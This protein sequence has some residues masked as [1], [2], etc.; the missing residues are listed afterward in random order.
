MNDPGDRFL[1][2]VLEDVEQ[3]F[4][5]ALDSARAQVAPEE[6]GR[7][8]QVLDSVVFVRG[9]PKTQA[10]EMIRFPG[11]TMGLAF[12]LDPGQ[13]GV[14]MLD[15]SEGIEAG[16]RARRTGRVMDVPVGEAVVGRVLDPVGRPLDGKGPIQTQDRLELER[17]AADILDRDPV[18]EPLQTG[19]KVID[20]LIPIGRGQRELIVGDRQTGKTAIAT[21]A[22][23]NQAR[24]NVTCIY[25]AIGRRKS[26]V[27]KVIADLE[28]RGAM[29]YSAVVVAGGEDAPG[30]RFAAPYSAMSMAE[31]LMYKGRDV[32]VVFDDLTR[33]ARAYRELSL[34]LRRPPGREAYPGDIFYIHSRLLER[35]THLSDQ[36]G[37][38][39]VTA[40]PI[41]ETQAQNISAYIPT[42]LISITD[43]QIYLSPTLFQQGQLPAVDVG[44]SVSRVGGKA[45][46]DP[47]RETAGDL[48][49]A[50]SQFEELERFSRYGTRLEEKQR[51]NLQHGRRV[52]AVM[53]QDQYDILSPAEQIVSLFVVS[54]GLLD[55][56]ELDEVA[57]VE[58][59]LHQLLQDQ[60]AELAQRFNDGKELQE[61]DRETLRELA[62][63]AVK[64][65]TGQEETGQGQEE[66]SQASNREDA[67][68][69][70]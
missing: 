64:E 30:L 49:L 17:P 24:S 33:H 20:A 65:V 59:K 52:R 15:R 48:R 55:E 9:L 8:Q 19:I 37:G 26:A 62:R 50:Y 31:H 34:L 66:D 54:Q 11:G 32:L 14:V 5:S 36:H 44:R 22:I 18:S 61:E 16:D 23:V 45:Q 63:R 60:Q 51:K 68:A 38:G 46:L 35:A 3:S 4:A 27:A 21:A 29:E 40:L 1:S 47:F 70:T 43:G 7:V 28:D 6:V 39:S 25:C 57:N 10:E 69:D 67:D 56:V 53:K 41:V 13:L 12:N 2:A 42:N 58:K